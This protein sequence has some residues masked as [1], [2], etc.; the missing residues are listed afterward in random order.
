V[1]GHAMN[2][3]AGQGAGVKGGILTPQQLLLQGD[4]KVMGMLEVDPLLLVLRLGERDAALQVSDLEDE[5]AQYFSPVNPIYAPLFQKHARIDRA[6]LTFDTRVWAQMA[7]MAESLEWLADRVYHL[8]VFAPEL[9]RL[10]QEGDAQTQQRGARTLYRRAGQKHA[11]RQ[12]GPH[13]D[14]FRK[15]QALERK[16]HGAQL[17][18]VLSRRSE[19]D[20]KRWS[21][22]ESCLS[23]ADRC[24]FLMR[25]ELH[26]HLFFFLSEMQGGSYWCLHDSSEPDAFVLELN[27]DLC[28]ID[29]AIGKYLGAARRRYVLGGTAE[30]V[31]QILVRNMALLQDKR[32]NQ[33][34]VAKIVRN[35][36]A[37]QQN[38]TNIE[39]ASAAATAAA[40]HAQS[41]GG[42][43][44]V[45]GSSGGR[46]EEQFDRARQYYE[47]LNFTQE[48]LLLWQ[49]ENPDTFSADEFAALMQ[50]QTH[51]R[52]GDGG[53]AYA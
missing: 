12:N 10:F 2:N 51:V 9:S 16:R 52:N 36:F 23:L 48:E 45:S 35:C 22:A 33:R 31:T 18:A 19:L 38:I 1:R 41:V 32:V 8:N 30:L 29:D 14:S 34:G 53:R 28:L 26:S 49:L 11:A 43:A 24:L 13:L 44:E 7:L 3:G 17:P 5:L 37:L 50:I 6:A 4:E 40:A 15:Q 20:Q 21:L 25:L 42:G 47:L 27:R 46:L 39:G